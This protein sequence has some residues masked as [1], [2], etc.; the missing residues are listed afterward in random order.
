MNVL[1]KKDCCFFIYIYFLILPLHRQNI[2]NDCLVKVFALN[3]FGLSPTLDTAFS[4]FILYYFRYIFPKA[5]YGSCLLKALDK[6]WLL[7]CDALLQK[8]IVKWEI[9]WDYGII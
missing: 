2:F 8:Q 3:K 4:T 1:F 9:F 6:Y 5:L 7:L